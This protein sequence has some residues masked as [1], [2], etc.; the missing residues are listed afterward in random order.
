[1]RKE[2]DCHSPTLLARL[3]PVHP[4]YSSSSAYTVAFPLLNPASQKILYSK[5]KKSGDLSYQ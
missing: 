3:D 4:G 5:P 1:M 2:I